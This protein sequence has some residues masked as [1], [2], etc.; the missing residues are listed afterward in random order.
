M[1]DDDILNEIDQIKSKI[2]NYYA[3]K[4]LMAIFVERNYKSN[5]CTINCFGVNPSLRNRVLRVF[6][7]QASLFHINLQECSRDTPIKLVIKKVNFI[8]TYIQKK[9]KQ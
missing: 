1:V 3:H 9:V 7:Q 4:S 2:T 8:T 6:S 5:H